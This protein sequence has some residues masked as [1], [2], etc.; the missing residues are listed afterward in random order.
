MS[1]AMAGGIGA[2]VGRVDGPDTNTNDQSMNTKALALDL[3][4]DDEV[5]PQFHIF[6]CLAILVI[7]TTLLAFNTQFMTHS[8]Q[9]LNEKAGVPRDFIGIILLPILGN[10][11]IAVQSAIRDKMDATIQA[12]LGKSLQ[13][14][15]FVIPVLILVA[16][17][18]GG[19]RYECCL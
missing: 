13:T 9:G 7:G 10:G 11:L 18:M 16:W 5:E 3:D 6:V 19:G 17:A 4:E 1:V 8:I 2:T 12:A 15:L 14:T